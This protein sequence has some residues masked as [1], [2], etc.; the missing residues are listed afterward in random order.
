MIL[1]GRE[2]RLGLRTDRSPAPVKVPPFE[3][4]FPKVGLAV[5]GDV[6][7]TPI[8][9]IARM[10]DASRQFVQTIRAALTLAEDRTVS[11]L[12]TEAS[13]RH[14][15]DKKARSR[16]EAELEAW[17]STPLS[18]PGA[19]VSY[20]EAVKKYPPQPK[21]E[22]CGLETFITGWIN[23]SDRAEK[24]K[25]QLTAWV[26]YCDRDKASY[27]LPFGQLTVRNRT[28]WVF[29]MSGRDHEWYAVADANPS[30]VRVIAEYFAGGLPR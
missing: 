25:T 1:A 24:L 28:H 15:F 6:D 20:I 5:A 12:A 30:R 3:L 16:V 9:N 29:Q 8:P 7:V 13:W 27:M 23:H 22:G 2:R 18:E 14:P 19:R 17:Y 4:P 26:M 21:D 11:G 10:D